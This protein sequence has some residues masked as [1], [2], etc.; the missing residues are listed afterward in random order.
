MK[1]HV[2]RYCRQAAAAVLLLALLLGT[3]ADAVVAAPR[4]PRTAS[5]GAV[6]PAQKDPD[7]PANLSGRIVGSAEIALLWSEPIGSPNPAWH[8]TTQVNESIEIAIELG[9]TVVSPAGTFYTISPYVYWAKNGALVVDYLVNPSKDD[10]G[11]A[12]WWQREYDTLPDPAFILPW[13]YDP[14]KAGQ[15]IEGFT[16]IQ[17]LRTKDITISPARPKPG[18]TVQLQATV[19]NYSFKSTASANQAVPVTVRFYLGD[20]AHGGELIATGATASSLGER[21][22]ETVRASWTV[23][24]DADWRYA[25]IYAVIDPDNAIAEIH[26]ENNK[27]WTVLDFVCAAC[28]SAPDLSIV[29]GSIQIFRQTGT[30]Y[31]VKAQIEAAGAGSAGVPVEFYAGN[32]GQQ[33]RKIGEDAIAKIKRKGLYLIDQVVNLAGGVNAASALQDEIWI[34][35]AAEGVE[36]SASSNNTAGAPVGN[37]VDPGSPLYLPLIQR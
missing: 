18:D 23:P 1:A 36:D 35:I 21:G 20:P 31:R 27:G 24:A 11:G 8:Y 17:R 29:P 2:A 19:H 4:L 9:K 25:R 34:Q 3:A 15:A 30:F 22:K 10:R 12:T 13:R 28:T 7:S 32:P 37:A 5:E 14:E 33:G 26:D 6:S 16:D